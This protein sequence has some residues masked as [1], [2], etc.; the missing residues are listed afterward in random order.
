MDVL[1]PSLPKRFII[2]QTMIEDLLFN[3]AMAC[4]IFF[5]LELDAF[6][7]AA[8][9][10]QW[11]TY[12]TEEHS[13]H[14]SSKTM[15]G[16]ILT[17]LS[18]VLIPETICG[19]IFQTLQAAIDH[20]WK[21]YESAY[22]TPL[23]R[24]QLGRIHKGSHKSKS[25]SKEAGNWKMYFRSGGRIEMPAP[26]HTGNAEK[27]GSWEVHRMLIDEANK[28]RRMGEGIENQLINRVRLQSFNPEHPV[29]QNKIW[30][31]GT[32][33]TADH[34]AFTFHKR[35]IKEEKKGNPNLISFGFC[36]KDWSNII[37][38][39]GK[40][41]RDQIP[42]WRAI[43][44]SNREMSRARKM[45]EGLGIYAENS[46][47]WYDAKW[48]E[49]GEEISRKRRIEVIL[50]RQMDPAKTDETRF[51]LGVDAA[52]SANKGNDEGA[53]VVLRAE[54][55][56]EMPSDNDS[57]WDLW[58]CYARVCLNHSAGMWSG[59]IHELHRAFGFTAVLMDPGGSDFITCELKKERQLIDG[60]ETICSPIVL[61]D[62]MTVATGAANFILFLTRSADPGLRNL[63]PDLQHARSGGGDT[64]KFFMNTAFQTA[65]EKNFVLLP[66]PYHELQRSGVVETWPEDKKK[67]S[68]I[69]NPKMKNQIISVNALM[70]EKG[71]Y[72]MTSN[73]AVQFVSLDKDDFHDGGRNAYV[74][75][76]IWLRENEGMYQVKSKD[77]G[78]FYGSSGGNRG[79][80]KS[81]V[82]AGGEG[83]VLA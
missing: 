55:L 1:V 44:N 74:A 21:Y 77:A 49:A 60:I 61:K 7:S 53:L 43:R 33:E 54:P 6:Q 16:W 14:G 8:L 42:N 64:L 31:M 48:F 26:G 22:M 10:M 4:K 3:P 78:M 18:C 65:W 23:F 39:T 58:Y 79:G 62:D 24:A 81:G 83:G 9:K 11:L 15:K 40:A 66:L 12:D 63:W 20:Y 67:A 80:F 17:N 27:L 38:P 29:W 57:D 75:F 30:R 19:V 76:K 72:K 5:N 73:N 32:A 68:R 41:F 34:P 46:E 47:G 71:A 70:D 36:Y 50:S 28:I 13:G 59:V 2:S 52:R 51:F 56:V 35:R 45:A 69:L 25:D 37:C 82:N